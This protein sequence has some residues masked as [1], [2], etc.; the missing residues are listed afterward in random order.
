MSRAV[1]RMLAHFANQFGPPP[2]SNIR[3]FFDDYRHHLGAVSDSILTRAVELFERHN[4]IP[5]WPTPGRILKFVDLATDEIVTRN[6]W[7]APPAKRIEGPKRTAAQ[8]A[9]VNAIAS[10]FIEE[11]RERERARLE[12]IAV[13]YL[14]DV[15]RP[16]MERR[17]QWM[18]DVGMALNTPTFQRGYAVDR[19]AYA[20]T[21]KNWKA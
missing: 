16:A 3:A 5:A 8:K 7:L 17:R 6:T 13:A 21:L 11:M 18:I 10:R 9:A 12:D 19:S 14:P 4:E 2:A 15:S 1:E 20:D